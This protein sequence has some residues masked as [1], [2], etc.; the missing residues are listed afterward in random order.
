MDHYSKYVKYKM[1]YID[2]KNKL[3]GGEINNFDEFMYKLVE[4]NKELL[5]F[6]NIESDK[7]FI[8]LNKIDLTEINN[9]LEQNQSC[10]KKYMEY[11]Q[12]LYSHTAFFDYDMIFTQLELNMNELSTTY[13]DYTHILCVPD[14]NNS[15]LNKSCVFYMLYFLNKYKEKF[16]NFPR[17]YSHHNLILEIKKQEQD[18]KLL[19]FCDDVIYSGMQIIK[20]MNGYINSINQNMYIYLNIFGFTQLAINNMYKNFNNFN[21]IYNSNTKPFNQTK[22]NKIILPSNLNPLNNS[23]Y[24][25]T[26]NFINDKN[27]SFIE[28]LLTYNIIYASTNEEIYC[29]LNEIIKYFNTHLI[30]LIYKFPDGLSTF[31][32][33]CH[34]YTFGEGM[35][36][37]DYSKVYNDYNFGIDSLP[38]IINNL[39]NTFNMNPQINILLENIQNLLQEIY[40]NEELKKKITEIQC[41]PPPS[42][43]ELKNVIINEK[44]QKIPLNICENLVVPFYK[45]KIYKYVIEGLKP[46]ITLDNLFEKIIDLQ[47]K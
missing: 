18:K 27:I 1:K 40:H 8:K 26:K 32:D 20:D 10:S 5:N 11:I 25:I 23:I 45:K 43:T 35:I 42:E 12:Y 4:E 17:I 13:S 41:K 9:Y 19:I 22:L 29:K 24:Q 16:G 6:K 36:N 44:L 2:L 28:F 15:A 3:S 37:L 46:D 39:F 30:Y 31:P 47:K 33:L 38:N 34:F 7:N 14:S 21:I